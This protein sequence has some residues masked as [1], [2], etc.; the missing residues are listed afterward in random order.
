MRRYLLLAVALLGPVVLM[1]QTRGCPS[2]ETILAVNETILEPT[3]YKNH[4]WETIALPS[5]LPGTTEG[6]YISVSGCGVGPEGDN[7]KISLRSSAPSSERV[8]RFNGPS[9]WSACHQCLIWVP[10]GKNLTIEH[11]LEGWS[12]PNLLLVEMNL[13]GYI[14]RPQ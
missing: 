11:T 8:C 10:V 3:H 14:Y 13:Y 2:Q 5:S 7:F 12:S 9:V 1:G 6:I 4:D